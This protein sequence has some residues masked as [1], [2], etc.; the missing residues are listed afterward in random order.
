[1]AQPQQPNQGQQGKTAGQ[2]QNKGQA[3]KTPVIKIEGHIGTIVQAPDTQGKEVFFAPLEIRVTDNNRPRPGVKVWA[4]KGVTDICSGSTDQNGFFICTDYTEPLE[5][6]GKTVALRLIADGATQEVNLTFELPQKKEEEKPKEP[7][8]SE[9][10][11]L[12]IEGYYKKDTND[13]FIYARVTDGMGKPIKEVTLMFIVDGT[14]FSEETGEDGLVSFFLSHHMEKK[15]GDLW[16]P[17]PGQLLKL[18]VF[19]PGI[20]EA[21]EITLYRPKNPEPEMGR[22]EWLWKKKNGW[23][24]LSLGFAFTLWI[25]CAVIGWGDP[26]INPPQTVLSPQQEIYNQ[27]GEEINPSEKKE[28]RVDDGLIKSNLK[29][30]KNLCLSMGSG[31]GICSPPKNNNGTEEQVYQAYGGQYYPQYGK[32]NWQKKNWI[33]TLIISFLSLIFA[34]FILREE[35]AA[36]IREWLRKVRVRSSSQVSDPLWEKLAKRFNVLSV[37]YKKRNGEE[38]GMEK[39]AA[40]H[41]F[42]FWDLFKSDLLSDMLVELLPALFRAVVKK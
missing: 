42:S 14:N 9:P 33:I 4:K 40:K 34:S 32:G 39:A 13:F 16:W 36:E 38:G 26:L 31:I 22:L 23:A 21:A 2:Q 17:D 20:E 8:K 25:Y 19:C 5:E 27:A 28:V 6:A 29:A 10:T 15:D 3:P 24:V 12:D 41:D 18:R 30:V 37:A 1:M 11:R 7:E 35:V